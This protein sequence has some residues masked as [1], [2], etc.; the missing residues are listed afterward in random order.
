MYD[1]RRSLTDKCIIQSFQGGKVIAQQEHKATV[2]ELLLEWMSSI[3]AMLGS[4][5]SEELGSMS[6]EKSVPKFPRIIPIGTHGDDKEVRAKKMEIIQELSSECKGKAFEHLLKDCVIVDNTTAGC[7]EKEDPSFSSIRKETHEFASKDLTEQTPVAWV[8]FRRVFQEVVKKLKSPIVPYQVVTEISTMCNIPSTATSTMIQFYHNLAVFFHYTKVPSLRNY[9]IADPQWLISQFAKILA[10]EGFEKF[11][12]ELLWKHLRERGVLVQPLYE[13]V[14][15]DSELSSQSLIDLLVHFLLAAPISRKSKVTNLPGKEYFVSL[16]LPAFT[17]GDDQ[18]AK[19]P[20]VVIK[21]AAPLHL[22]FNTYYVPPGFFSRLVTALLNNS[23]FQV[24]FSEG[25]YRDRI[26]M[27]YGEGHNKIDEITLTKCKNSIQIS[28]CRTQDRPSCY[29]P[30]SIMCRN[31]LSII[32]KC[33]P[34][35][36]HW[37]KGIEINYAFACECCPKENSDQQHFIRISLTD[38]VYTKLR[39]DKLQYA[40]L[41][42][43][44]QC[45]LRFSEDYHLVCNILFRLLIQTSLCSFQCTPDLKDTDLGLV[46][47]IIQSK[48]KVK[49]LAETLEMTDNLTA[50]AVHPNPA[51]ELLFAWSIEMQKYV[52]NLRAHLAHHLTTIG[53]NAVSKR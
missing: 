10:L 34:T 15:K 29:M 12:N 36:L 42:A 21:Q 4:S 26:L 19:Q 24:A 31:I 14:W 51:Y 37:L 16:V 23:N 47:E 40:N 9:V 6:S 17:F 50:L 8:L 33:F 3:H 32:N 20:Y 46:G 45:W 2:L 53:M 7:G 49:E 5:A 44:H 41:T 39:C 28:I 25:V 13:Q 1:A 27:L 11:G 38:T 22:L 30:F 52:P 18:K 35:I 43:S 48:E